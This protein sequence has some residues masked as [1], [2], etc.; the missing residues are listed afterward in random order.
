MESLE[1]ISHMTRRGTVV[2]GLFLE[3][4]RVEGSHQGVDVNLV[5][6][7]CVHTIGMKHNIQMS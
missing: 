3:L 1:I 4:G 7:L 6:S 2:L 5:K